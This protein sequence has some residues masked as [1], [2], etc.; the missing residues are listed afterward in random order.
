MPPGS[1]SAFVIT[2]GTGLIAS[3]N[4]LLAMPIFP[5]SVIWIVNE[6]EPIVV[7][8]PLRT[9]VVAFSVMPG[10]NSPATTA[11]VYG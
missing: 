1:G 4:A 9:P 10:G 3:V 6:L 7:G 11:H 8:V 5:D 2:S